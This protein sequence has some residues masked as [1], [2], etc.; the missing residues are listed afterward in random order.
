MITKLILTLTFAF[1]TTSHV[2][3]A[4]IK[5]PSGLSARELAQWYTNFIRQ[6][7]TGGSVSAQI[8]HALQHE[9]W[10]TVALWAFTAKTIR[11]T[12]SKNKKLL[13]GFIQE[14]ANLKAQTTFPISLGNNVS[15]PVG[16]TLED[17]NDVKL[18]S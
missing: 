18:M 4:R 16:S 6:V 2:F 12:P 15:L 8:K 7:N 17:L 9:N 13:Q 1:A 10:V 11:I 3:C 14:G 5:E